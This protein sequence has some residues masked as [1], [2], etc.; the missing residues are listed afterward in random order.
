MLFRSNTG[1]AGAMVLFNG[2]LGT[3]SSGTVTNLTGTASININGTVGATTPAAGSFSTVNASGLVNIAGTALGGGTGG[4]EIGAAATTALRIG[5]SSSRNV[6]L[7]W[8]YNATAANA[9]AYL[10]T[11]AGA[12]KLFIQSAGGGGALQL[13]GA[14]SAVTIPGTLAVTGALSATGATTLGSTL[15]VTAASNSLGVVINGRSSD[16]LGALYYYAN[17]GST[18]H[19]TL[20]ASATEFRLSSVPAAA[21][22]TFYTNG[23][24]RMRLNTTGALVLA[25][26]STSASGIGIAFPATQSASSDANTLDDYEEGTWTPNVNGASVGSFTT[27]TGYYVKTGRQ[28]TCWFVCDGGNTGGGGATQYVTGLPFTITTAIHNSIMGQMGTNGPATR[29]LDLMALNA[30][31]GVAY[32]Y[33]GGS[34]EQTA[35]SFASGCFTYGID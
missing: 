15:T 8:L 31:F 20:T 5:Q 30:N 26:G 25:G 11:Y 13:G 29:T 6:L 24:E 32:V 7:Y 10:E 14:S 35:I 27:K 9:E 12:N 28:V 19:A 4:I 21:V 33:T 1:S 2:A 18:Q 34:Q 3:P 17:N 23:S 22:Q 16:N